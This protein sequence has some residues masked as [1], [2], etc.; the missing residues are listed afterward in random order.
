MLVYVRWYVAYLLSMPHIEEMRAER[1]TPVVHAAFHRW[2]HKILPLC[3]LQFLAYASTQRVRVGVWM[4]SLSGKWISGNIF[5][6]PLKH[7]GKLFV[8]LNTERRATAARCFLVRAI[9]LHSAPEGIC[10]D[11]AT[12]NQASLQE[13]RPLKWRS[14]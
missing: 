3:W 4:R 7:S 2:S 13:R 11:G 5:T 6:G 9:R 8:L 10:I 12:A 14:Q 1:G